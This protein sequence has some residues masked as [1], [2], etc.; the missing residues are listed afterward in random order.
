MHEYS[1]TSVM[2]AKP[3]LKKLKKAQKKGKAKAK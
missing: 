3:R 2:T 1:G